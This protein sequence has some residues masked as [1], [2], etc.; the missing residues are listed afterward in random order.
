MIEL[1]LIPI[2]FLSGVLFHF[3]YKWTNRSHIAVVF[4]AVNESLWEHMKI[5]FW[6]MFIGFNI[7]YILYGYDIP[8]FI[9][10]KFI[11]LLLITITIPLF[12]KTYTYFTKKNIFPIDLALFFLCIAI[13]QVM[14]YSI[15]GSNIP[16]IFDVISLP[17]SFILVIIYSS[18]T[19]LPPKADIFKDPISGIYG[20]KPHSH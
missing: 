6:P 1:I 2:Y 17:L 7:Q 4:G 9:F 19:K 18:L 16:E 5:A 8:N 14:G 10:S 11:S 3:I 13:S 20:E 15:M 12:V